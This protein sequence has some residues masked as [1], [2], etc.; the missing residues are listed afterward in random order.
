[1]KK[2]EKKLLE[3]LL[4]NNN[5]IGNLGS[6]ILLTEEAK[7]VVKE[8]TKN[9][10]TKKKKKSNKSIDEKWEMFK[11]MR[12]KSG[13]GPPDDI[14]DNPYYKVFEGMLKTLI[15]SASMPDL[16]PVEGMEN[17]PKCI[18]IYPDMKSYEE[19]KKKY[20]FEDVAPKPKNKD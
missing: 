3:K 18:L 10:K 20:G 6:P 1:M 19:L 16:K 9:K 11:E 14:K 7:D 4:T 15:F 13:L 5:L 12:D 17:G 2:K 8:L